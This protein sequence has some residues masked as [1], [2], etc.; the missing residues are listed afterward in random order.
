MTGSFLWTFF[1]INFPLPLSFRWFHDILRCFFGGFPR[2]F[3]WFHVNVSG[4]LT[5]SVRISDVSRFLKIFAVQEST[6]MWKNEQKIKILPRTCDFY[7]FFKNLRLLFHFW[8]FHDFCKKF[9]IFRDFSRF[10]MILDHVLSENR[11][12]VGYE[13]RNRILK[14]SWAWVSLKFSWNHRNPRGNPQKKHLKMSR[15]DRMRESVAKILRK[16]DR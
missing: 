2:G 10:F 11:S 4:F 5:T 16:S 15:N 1:R 14:G 9:S 8:F 3:R 13:I 7:E 6:K 12:F